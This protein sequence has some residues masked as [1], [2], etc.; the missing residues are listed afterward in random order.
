M[1]WLSKDGGYGIIWVLA[2]PS[3]NRRE[4]RPVVTP[5]EIVGFVM[6]VIAGVV[7]CY[8]YDLIMRHTKGK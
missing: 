1:E 6:S 4:V 3:G 8:I 2:E 7:S 5:N